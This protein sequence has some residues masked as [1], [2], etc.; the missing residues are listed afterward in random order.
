[1]TI[2]FPVTPSCDTAPMTNL[3]S[4]RPQGAASS[5][6]D[7][8]VAF[9]VCEAFRAAIEH[10]EPVCASCG[11][12]ADDH[13]AS[14]ARVTRLRSRRPVGRAAPDRKAS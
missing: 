3:T 14:E 9:E 2:P 1:V 11:H 7:D 8:R 10:D 6:S 4:E 12:L 13:A 5:R